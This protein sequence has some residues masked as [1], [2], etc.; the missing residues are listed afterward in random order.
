MLK[1]YKFDNILK[2]CKNILV[3]DPLSY[4]SFMNL[5]MNSK[6]VITDSGGIQEETTYM[7]IPCLTL[8]PNTERP[9]TISR[10]T[11]QLCDIQNLKDKVEKI[12]TSDLKEKNPIELW[13]GKTAL[14]VVNT[15]QNFLINKNQ[16][17]YIRKPRISISK[18]KPIPVKR[19]HIK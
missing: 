13:D 14:R 1:E 4:I 16:L 12:L 15:M 19:K 5:V 9:V 17:R 18:K 2:R 8:R 10:G 7:N 11:N 6:L 3:I